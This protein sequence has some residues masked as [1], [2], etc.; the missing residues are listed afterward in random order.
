MAA[1]EVTLSYTG[2]RADENE[3]EF[4]DVAQALIGFQR[5]SP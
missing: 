5:S 2:F 4:Y 1:V 3:I